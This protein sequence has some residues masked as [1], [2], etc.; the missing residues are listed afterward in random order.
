MRE[1]NLPDVWWKYNAVES[2]QSRRF[3]ECVEE[4]FLTQLVSEPTR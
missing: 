4:N 1:F 3:L 2:K